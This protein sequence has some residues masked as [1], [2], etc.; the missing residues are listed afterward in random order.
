MGRK[1]HKGR[2]RQDERGKERTGKDDNLLQKEIGDVS[3]RCFLYSYNNCAYFY[4][5]HS[6]DI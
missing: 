5:L 1:L 2:M 3:E 4:L 6:T